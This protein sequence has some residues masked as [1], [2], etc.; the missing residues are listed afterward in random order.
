MQYGAWVKVN[1]RTQPPCS[2]ATKKNP[3]R[4]K[5]RGLVSGSLN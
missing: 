2:A 1:K 5:A 4:F 3:E